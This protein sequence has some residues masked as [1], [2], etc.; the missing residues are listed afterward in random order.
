[1]LYKYAATG[2]TSKLLHESLYVCKYKEMHTE[3]HIPFGYTLY[4]EVCILQLEFSI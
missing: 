1:M 4:Y 3:V 2:N